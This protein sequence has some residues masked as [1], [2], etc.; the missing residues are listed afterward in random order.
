VKREKRKEKREKNIN[1]PYTTRLSQF[2]IIGMHYH[3]FKMRDV[4]LVLQPH[5]PSVSEQHSNTATPH[6]SNT[7][8]HYHNST[9]TQLQLSFHIYK[10]HLTFFNL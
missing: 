6:H 8:T 4:I 5:N 1:L 3:L 2:A 7:A 9:A 10:H